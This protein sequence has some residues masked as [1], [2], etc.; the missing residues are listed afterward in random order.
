[1][2]RGVGRDGGLCSEGRQ[3]A[4]GS[5]HLLSPAMAVAA[6]VIGYLVDVRELYGASP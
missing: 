2:R 5:T 3:G 1:V 6:A 4:G